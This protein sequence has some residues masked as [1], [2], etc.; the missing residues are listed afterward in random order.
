MKKFAELPVQE[1]FDLLRQRHRDCKVYVAEHR[2]FFN[3]LLV[4]WKENFHI[5][6]NFP[7]Y[8]VA[9]LDEKLL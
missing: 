4:Q 2:T 1:Q 5:L 8:T 3:T 7:I 6:D 9:V